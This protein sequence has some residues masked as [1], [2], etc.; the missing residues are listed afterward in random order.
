MQALPS[1]RPTRDNG[2]FDAISDPTTPGSICFLSVA[3][4]SAGIAGLE[5]EVKAGC[6]PAAT[7]QWR[8]TREDGEGPGLRHLRGCRDIGSRSFWRRN[9]TLLLAGVFGQV[10]ANAVNHSSAF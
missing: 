5:R 6:K 2:S 1:R 8:E 10:Q 3:V 7:K 9:K 4:C